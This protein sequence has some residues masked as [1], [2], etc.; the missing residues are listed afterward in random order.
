MSIIGRVGHAGVMDADERANL[1]SDL[2]LHD[3][4]LEAL[5]RR[6]EVFDLVCSS[7]TPDEAEQ[8]I[9]D[10]FRVAEPGISRVVLD[11]Q[12]SRWTRRERERIYE[13]ANELRE[14]WAASD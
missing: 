12:M 10:L 7:E 14:T 11:M 9:R 8:R 13:R 2:R 4:L 1:E 6:Q 5:D 3:L